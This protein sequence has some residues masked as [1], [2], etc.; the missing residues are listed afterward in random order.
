[1]A[2]SVAVYIIENHA[3]SMRTC[4]AMLA[5]IKA[6]GDQAAVIHEHGYDGPTHGVAVFY[7]MAGQLPRIFNDHR[8]EGRTA[9][10]IDLGYWQRKIKARFDGYHK[11]SVGARHPTAYFQQR[12]HCRS[13]IDAL[14]VTAKSWRDGTHVL[15]AGMGDKGAR[16]EGFAPEQWERD[17]IARLRENTDRPI[18]Y[19]PKPSWKEAK[20]IEGVGY[21]P[22]TE[23]I[24][25]ALKDCHAV[26]THHS[27]AAVDGLVD[28]VPVFCWDGVAAPMALQSLKQIEQP[29]RPD[30]RDEWLAAIA[31]TQFTLDEMAEG[32]PWRHLKDEGLV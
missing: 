24:E 11:V 7:G 27:N 12:S 32:L 6:C 26:V 23:T 4:A 16:A 13:R 18:I 17:A 3:R 5:G 31:W 19:R 22:R 25:A 21:S 10:Y 14:G 30:G 1:M 20:P 2:L 29:H 15:V 28:G 9:I 8:K